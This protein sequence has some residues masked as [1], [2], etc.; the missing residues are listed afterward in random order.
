MSA[1]P[2]EA[3]MEIERLK[4]QVAHLTKQ[5]DTLLKLFKEVV[6]PKIEMLEQTIKTLRD[7]REVNPEPSRPPGSIW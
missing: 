1:V 5:R 6:V 3:Q 4:K 2:Y 7:M